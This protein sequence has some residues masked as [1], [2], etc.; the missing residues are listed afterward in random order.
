LSV[1]G[2]ELKAAIS[3]AREAGRVLREGFGW[4]H[5]VRYKGEVDLVTEVDKQQS[6]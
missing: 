1:T 4:Q 2:N 6:R 3:A 5:S